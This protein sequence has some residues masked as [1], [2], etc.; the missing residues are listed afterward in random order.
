MNTKSV[1]ICLAVIGFTALVFALSGPSHD[2]DEG[3]CF[4]C[5][6]DPE[7]YPMR[8]QPSVS[9][10]CNSCHLQLEKKKSHP[11]DIY[12]SMTIPADM[13]L[14]EGKMTCITCH[15][16]H[17]K[18]NFQFLSKQHYYLRRQ[19]KGVFFCSSC[20]KIDDKG[21]IVYANIHSGSYKV[22]DTGTRIDKMSLECIQCHDTYLKDNASSLGAGTWNHFRESLPHPIGISY[23]RI[24]SEK[25]SDFKSPGMLNREI[26]FFDDN[27]GCG[28][29]HNIYSK[30]KN[31]LVMA[32]KGQLCIECHNK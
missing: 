11:S 2:F 19:V 21:H 15:F 20:H 4:H 29:C 13:P 27:I 7:N 26:R 8:F 22:T 23:K 32:N 18:E 10:A 24:Q 9:R 1:I 6:T 28:T 31:M 16:A 14:V 5:H 12:P 25:M 3:Q 30:A 17:P